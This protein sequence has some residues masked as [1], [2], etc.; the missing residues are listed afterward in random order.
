ME[1]NIGMKK[2]DL[3]LAGAYHEISIL[4]DKYNLKDYMES[5]D[6]RILAQAYSPYLPAEAFP[7]NMLPMNFGELPADQASLFLMRANIQNFMAS[8]YSIMADHNSDLDMET[9][10]TIAD[11]ISIL[12]SENSELSNQL[13]LR[14]YD[15]S[16]AEIIEIDKDSDKYDSFEPVIE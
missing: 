5:N 16:I 13:D 2:I 3:V 11:T 6:K 14:L 7:G 10:S 4:V 12:E 1:R 15:V 9:L 8:L